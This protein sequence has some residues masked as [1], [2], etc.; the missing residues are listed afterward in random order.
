[1]KG[2]IFNLLQ[3]A[4]TRQFGPDAWDDLIDAAG[5]DGAYTSLGNYHDDEITALVAQA[6]QALG[7]TRGDVLRW[8]GQS[9]IPMLAARYPEFFTGHTATRNF[10]LTLNGIIHPE[11][12]K[13]YPGAMPPVFGFDEGDPDE[14]VMTYRS[15]RHLCMLAEGFITGSA[16]YFGQQVRMRQSQ[17]MHD[18]AEHCT[19]H[20]RFDDATA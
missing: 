6:S 13:I 16:Q 19:F 1:M 14:L 4:V 9:T 8:F 17:C 12:R 7:M 3:E 18:G 20:L 2:I 5:V 10:L 11:V 15:R